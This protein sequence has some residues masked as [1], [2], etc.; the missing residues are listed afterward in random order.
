L[1]DILSTI[2]SVWSTSLVSA[3]FMITAL[4]IFTCERTLF[5]DLLLSAVLV[6]FAIN[7]FA[8]VLLTF[9]FFTA[10]IVACAINW[11]TD[12]IQKDWVGFADVAT[13]VTIIN[14]WSESLTV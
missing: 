5:T 10:V 7:F 2:T 1:V 3:V 6:G 11:L 9:F 12:L 8:N 14:E 13:I 4:N